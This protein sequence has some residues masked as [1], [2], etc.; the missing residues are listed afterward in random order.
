MNDTAPV[1]P[2][3]NSCYFEELRIRARS[4]WHREQYN[5][6]LEDA[7]SAGLTGDQVRAYAIGKMSDSMR[8][9]ELRPAEA[10]PD[11]SVLTD[12]FVL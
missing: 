12:P 10:G 3:S 5:Q 9:S 1:A 8:E 6:Q 2:L 7:R 4:P 11:A